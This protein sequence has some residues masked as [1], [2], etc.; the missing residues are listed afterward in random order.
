MVILRHSRAIM[1]E[2]CTSVFYVMLLFLLIKEL[3]LF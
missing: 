2:K 1:A 3:L